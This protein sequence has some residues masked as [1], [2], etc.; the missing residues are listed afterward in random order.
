MAALPRTTSY[1]EVWQLC[2]PGEGFPQQ[3]CKTSAQLCS[4]EGVTAPHSYTAQQTLHT[5]IGREKSRTVTASAPG[6]SSRES[7]SRHR[8]SQGAKFSRAKISSV[9]IGG[10]SS[11]E[12]EELRIGEF[13]CSEIGVIFVDGG[14]FF[15][16]PPFSYFG[17]MGED[18]KTAR[19]AGNFA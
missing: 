5:F 9:G 1:T 7:S 17:P 16:P 6:R 4:R 8:N 10:I 2:S 11:L 14:G 3:K 15:F 12:L 18:R 19:A 13:S